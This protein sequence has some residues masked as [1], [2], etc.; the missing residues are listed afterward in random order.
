[1]TGKSGSGTTRH[2]TW[3]ARSDR[4]VVVDGNDTLGLDAGRILYHYTSFSLS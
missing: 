3:T 4:G 2:F 1:V